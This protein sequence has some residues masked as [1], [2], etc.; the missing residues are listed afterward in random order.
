[1]LFATFMVFLVFM[2]FKN[3][4]LYIFG[5]DEKAKKGEYADKDIFI[6]DNDDNRNRRDLVIIE[7]KILY[8]EQNCDCGEVIE[9]FLFQMNNICFEIRKKIK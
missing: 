1:M 8:G 6:C 2:F 9:Y 3:F 5:F 7:K 4:I